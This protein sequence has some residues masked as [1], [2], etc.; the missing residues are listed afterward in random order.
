MAIIR[1]FSFLN[2]F[3]LNK[4]FIQ[5][6][7]KVAA[8]RKKIQETSGL[9]LQKTFVSHT[10]MAH[11]RWATHGQPSERNSH[12]HRSDPNNTFLVVHN[13][14]ITNYKELRLVLEKKGYVFESDTDTECIAK[15]AKYF[16]DSQKGGNTLTFTN[17]VKAVVKELV[18]WFYYLYSFFRKAHLPL[19]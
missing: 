1:M 12:P 16:Y 10:S 9:D 13:G 14:I 3:I 7:G 18:I 5:Q 19:F 8:L 2:R 11:T 17:L 4:A 15:L 6:V